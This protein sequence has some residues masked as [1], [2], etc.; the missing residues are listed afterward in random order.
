MFLVLDRLELN[1]MDDHLNKQTQ[2]LK[3]LYEATMF[4][5]STNQ[6]YCTIYVKESQ[7]HF[8]LENIKMI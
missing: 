5:F 3:V 8:K 4:K 2:S 7:L 1:I 6:F